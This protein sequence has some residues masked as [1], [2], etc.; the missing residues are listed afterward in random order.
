MKA[1]PQAQNRYGKSHRPVVRIVVLHDVDTGLA[2]RPY[3]GPM[4]GPQAVSEQALAEQATKHAAGRISDRRPEFRYLF[5]GLSR[6]GA[7]A[8]NRHPLDRSTGAQTNGRRDF[9][10]H[11]S[12]RAMADQPVGWEKESYLARR[13]QRAGDG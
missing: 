12:I 2:E 3:W 13:C 1:Y 9:P 11:R 6:T 4:Y 5:C 8:W 7:R 10:R